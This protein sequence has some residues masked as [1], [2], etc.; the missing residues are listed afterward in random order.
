MESSVLTDVV[1]VDTSVISELVCTVVNAVVCTSALFVVAA[2]IREVDISIADVIA[3]FVVV[4]TSLICVGA[5]FVSD[6]VD[7]VPLNSSFIVVNS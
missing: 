4:N 5:L 2:I 1:V 3:L 7:T 6:S